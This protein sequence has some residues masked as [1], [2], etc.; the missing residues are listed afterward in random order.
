MKVLDQVIPSS[1]AGAREALIRC[2]NA[3]ADVCPVE[4]VILFGS[5]ARGCSGAG[6]DVDLCIVISGEESQLS[7][8]RRLRRAIGR[9]RDKPPL[10]LV[11]IS[12]ERLGEKLLL[13]DPFYMTLL[14]EGIKIGA[15]N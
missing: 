13:E 7:A 9:L 4:E 3:F 10:S 2:L 14:G 15:K 8:A 6:S 5:H 11:V 1:L 12:T